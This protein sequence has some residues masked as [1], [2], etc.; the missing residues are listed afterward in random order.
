MYKMIRLDVIKHYLETGK[1]VLGGADSKEDSCGFCTTSSHQKHLEDEYG[2]EAAYVYC[3]S[4]D[5]LGND[6]EQDVFMS[7]FMWSLQVKG[8]SYQGDSTLYEVVI[9]HCPMCGRELPKYILHLPA[10]EE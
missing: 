1:M 9:T 7:K 6:S 3:D 5:M 4:R 8:L 10:D 2:K